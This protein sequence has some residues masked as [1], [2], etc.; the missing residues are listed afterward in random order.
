MSC[1]VPTSD[2]NHALSWFVLTLQLS[3]FLPLPG[4]VVP[5]TSILSL[6]VFVCLLSFIFRDSWHEVP[7]HDRLCTRFG[8][9]LHRASFRFVVFHCV[10]S[11]LFSTPSPAFV[12][13]GLSLGGSLLPLFFPRS[14]H[15]LPPF[16]FGSLR[17]LLLFCCVACFRASF[18]QI[19][20]KWI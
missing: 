7:L 2:M 6:S 15:L 9:S 20:Q 10:L 12:C 1:S 8:F 16:F 17:F 13:A 5:V 3:A 4:S 11:S 18:S 14:F 19:C